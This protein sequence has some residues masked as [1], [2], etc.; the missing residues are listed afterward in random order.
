[1][2]TILTALTIVVIF[3]RVL[4]VGMAIENPITSRAMVRSI[5]HLVI[6]SITLDCEKFLIRSAWAI[7][8]SSG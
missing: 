5:P 7:L 8:I 1:M 6:K 4:K 3:D 2:V